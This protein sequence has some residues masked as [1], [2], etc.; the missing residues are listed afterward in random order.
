MLQYCNNASVPSLDADLRASGDR[1]PPGKDMDGWCTY[2]RS[3]MWRLNYQLS[4]EGRKRFFDEFLP[5]LHST[6]HE[7]MG[8]RDNDSWYLVYIGTKPKARGKGYATK[9][10]KYGTEKVR[11]KPTRR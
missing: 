5:V 7:V 3:G 1:M 2:L 10:I 8:D 4:A 6:K 11:L 9:S